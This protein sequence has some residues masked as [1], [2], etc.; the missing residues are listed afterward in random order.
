MK[1][2]CCTLEERG[3]PATYIG[4]SQS[5]P[6]VNDKI[7]NKDFK[8]VVVSSQ[9]PSGEWVIIKM[10]CRQS[11]DN[12]PMRKINVEIKATCAWVN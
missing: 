12:N 7:R 1:D 8:I 2:Q 10:I 6:H 4:S 3:I 11:T 5:D 9:E